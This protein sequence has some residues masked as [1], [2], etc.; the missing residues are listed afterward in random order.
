M[1][2]IAEQFV[3]FK[4]SKLVKGSGNVSVLDA[5]TVTALEQV[6]SDAVAQ[7]DPGAVVEVEAGE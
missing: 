4:V 7:I 2:Q 6:V 3:V 1:A 5:E